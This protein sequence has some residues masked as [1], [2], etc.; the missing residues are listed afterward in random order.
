MDDEKDIR[1]VVHEYLLREGDNI[2]Q[3]IDWSLIF[4]AILLEALFASPRLRFSVPILS[5]GLAIS[6]LWLLVGLRQHWTMT[7]LF[8]AVTEI[9]DGSL[10]L[11]AVLKG[12]REAQRTRQPCWYRWVQATPV[13]AI[14][15]PSLT[16]ATWLALFVGK[17]ITSGVPWYWSV[18][19][20]VTVI[21]GTALLSWAAMRAGTN[22]DV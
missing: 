5:L 10:R 9:S 21:V 12:I 20:P 6:A 4:H 14:V 1:T 13:F 2:S 7:L 3:R 8:K 11:R 16:F 19:A 17:L 15:I 22:S 18:S